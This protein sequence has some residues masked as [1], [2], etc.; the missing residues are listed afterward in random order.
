MLIVRKRI[1]E[2]WYF[3]KMEYYLGINKSE[4]MSFARTWVEM[5]III[6][7]EVRYRKLNLVWFILSTIYNLKY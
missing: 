1:N 3:C 4:S 2:M 7:S 5:E 6:F